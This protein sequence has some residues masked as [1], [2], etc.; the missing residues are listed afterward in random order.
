MADANFMTGLMQGFG[1]VM[2]MKQNQ[3]REDEMKKLQKKLLNTQLEMQQKKMSGQQQLTDMMTGFPLPEGQ[4]GPTVPGM[5]A[6]EVLSSPQGQGAFLQ[7][8]G[9]LTDLLTMQS[10][11]AGKGIAN[12]KTQ[13]EIG[14]LLQEQQVM[15]Q[16]LNFFKN[17]MNGGVDGQPGGIDT[18]QIDP[19]SLVAASANVDPGLLKPKGTRYVDVYNEQTGATDKQL[20]DDF[21]NPVLRQG[22]PIIEPGKPQQ[23]SSQE[24]A[25]ATASQTGIKYV[26]ELKSYF[27]NPDGTVNPETASM[28]AITK[29][30]VPGTRENGFLRKFEDTIDAVVRARTGATATIPEM[31]NMINQFVPKPWDHEDTIKDKFY[32]LESF[33]QGTYD[34]MN[35]PERLKL[36]W[37]KKD[38]DKIGVK[39]IG[40]SGWSPTGSKIKKPEGVSEEEWQ[41][42]QTQPDLMEAYK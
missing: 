2:L 9:S 7:S 3:A 19:V 10:G 6:L 40:V 26:G 28:T 23:L 34:S 20:V 38:Q 13:A 30:Y 16:K 25:R 5:S 11:L 17:L 39:E 29:M 4:A 33:L 12:Q 35:L 32:R 8:G 18:S 21:G 1:N 42:I 22:E 27:L 36:K 15:E 31:N 41:F 24:A 14:K 37:D